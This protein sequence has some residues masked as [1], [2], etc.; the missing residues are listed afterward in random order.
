M[1]YGSQDEEAE[2]CNNPEYDLP[3][4]LRRRGGDMA[5]T[6]YIK[7]R[8]VTTTPVRRVGAPHIIF[9]DLLQLRTVCTPTSTTT[10]LP[11][12]WVQRILAA[13]ACSWIDSQCEAE[14][15]IKLIHDVLAN[16]PHTG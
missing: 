5:R 6:S 7:D 11:G 3:G 12:F 4:L 8:G 10:G 13:V 16:N 9:V 2:C 14:Q 1:V 15:T